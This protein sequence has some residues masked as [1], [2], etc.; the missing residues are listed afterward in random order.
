M[1]DIIDTA[2]REGKPHN[3]DELGHWLRYHASDKNGTKHLIEASQRAL[4]DG[5]LFPDTPEE[6]RNIVRKYEYEREHHM[7]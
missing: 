4:Q 7:I 6:A 3:W 5:L 1:T 2:F